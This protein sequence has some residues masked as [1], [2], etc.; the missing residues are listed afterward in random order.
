MLLSSVATVGRRGGGGRRYRLPNRTRLKEK[1]SAVVN[2]GGDRWARRELSGQ[3]LCCCRWWRRWVVVA[4]AVGGTA[5]LTVP[6]ARRKQQPWRRGRRPVSQEGGE[7]PT[8]VLLS[9][10]ATVGCRG[11]GGGR[12]NRLSNRTCVKGLT[13]ALTTAAA[14]GVRGGRCA[15]DHFAVSGGE[16][17]RSS[18]RRWSPSFPRF[19]RQ[20]PRPAAAAPTGAVRGERG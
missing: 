7:R 17:G 19:Q 5:C 9:A 10:V 3:R 2:A 1:A 14:T 16:R 15:I 20:P 11:G 6:A 18:R 13:A 8:T 12:W 4:A